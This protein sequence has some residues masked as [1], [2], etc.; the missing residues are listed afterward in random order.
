MPT[1][2]REGQYRVF[3]FS[4]DCAEPAHVHVQR[5][6]SVAKIW[7]HDLSVASP[8]SYAA[9]ELGRIITFVR[10]N[11]RVLQD[12]WDEHCDR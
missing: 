6:R 3:F 2:L 12:R 10:Q 4:A 8:G 7:L 11:R 9:V 5:E 1:V